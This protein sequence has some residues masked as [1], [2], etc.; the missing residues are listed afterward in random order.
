MH[1]S[2]TSQSLEKKKLNIEKFS[3]FVNFDM[4]LKYLLEI[5]K[6]KCNY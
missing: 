2:K 3:V 1:N 6:I 4:K 5:T